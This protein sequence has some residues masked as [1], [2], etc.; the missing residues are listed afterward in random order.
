MKCL[1]LV[2][3][4]SLLFFHHD[5][6]KSASGKAELSEVRVE[7]LAQ[8]ISSWNGDKLPAYPKGQPE[9]TILKITVPPKTKLDMHT[10][11]FINAGVLLKGELHVVTADGKKLTLKEGDS[12][13]E[14][15]GKEHFGENKTDKPAE[16][17][18]FYAGIQGKLVTRKHES[19]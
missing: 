11:P 8:S 13:V 3:S 7:K 18:V 12:I 5:D 15:V 17:I 1:C 2:L 10:H 4:A 14:L 16:I 6:H 19:P 9:V